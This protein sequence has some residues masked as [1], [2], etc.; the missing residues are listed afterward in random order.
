[1]HRYRQ[2]PP[3]EIATCTPWM[4]IWSALIVALTVAPGLAQDWDSVPLI[5]HRAY[6]AVRPDGSSAYA[7]PI[8][9][10][11][12]GVVLNQ[13]EDWLH[14][15]EHYNEIPWNLG[16]QA[17]IFVQA[18]DLDGT[19]WDSDPGQPFEDY[20]GTAAWMGQCY[21]NLGFI[22]DPAF[23]YIDVTMAGP[24][25]ETRPVW[26]DE[27]DRL[28]LN[29]PGTPLAADQIVRA[30]DLVEL[31][32]RVNGL[33]YMGKHNVNERHHNEAPNDYEIVVL[34]K[35]YGLPPRAV[36]ALDLLKDSNDNAIFDPSRQTGGEHYQGSLVQVA[37]ITFDGLSAGDPLSSDTT[38]LGVDG[39]GRSLEVYLGLN[40]SFDSGFV[41]DGQLFSTGILDQVAS[42]AAGM[43]G[44]R[45]L[46]MHMAHIQPGPLGDVNRDGMVDGL[47][48]SPFVDVLLH[49]PFNPVAD[50]NTDGAA[51]GLDVQP[52]V[53]AVIRGGML[54]PVPEPPALLVTVG[55][56]L[57][58]AGRGR[59][60][61]GR[62]TLPVT[63]G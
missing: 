7:G 41:P 32:A 56:L 38:L 50:M 26:Y 28:N 1:M 31:R 19:P 37:G 25:G 59:W 57:G 14:A 2:G 55:V 58:M 39:T 24:P 34:A 33:N 12:Q 18:V 46:V 45:L 49:G 16:G 13:T 22:N 15:T 62:H 10:R 3:S 27:L 51:N 63:S 8:P 53:A 9:F 44:Y 54:Q 43:D 36:L 60:R 42:T 11:M 30:G 21:G 48:V 4:P 35:G 29:R 61:H 6:Q 17:E 20:G 47:D 52:F 23:S 40:E 5:E